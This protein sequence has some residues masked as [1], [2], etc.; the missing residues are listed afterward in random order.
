MPTGETMKDAPLDALHI[1]SIL[2]GSSRSMKR[3]QG[4]I[5]DLG[6]RVMQTRPGVRSPIGLSVVLHIPGNVLAPEFVGVRTESSHR[7]ETGLTVQ[8]ALEM[9]AS[10]DVDLRVW[11]GLRD[12]VKEAEVWAQMKRKADNLDGIKHL[13]EAV[14]P[15]RWHLPRKVGA[16]SPDSIHQ[17]V[18]RHRDVVDGTIRVVVG[19]A[20]GPPGGRLRQVA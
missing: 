11:E 9:E 5:R 3:W 7:K 2:G 8:I 10:V 20:H 18:R 15:T 17:P 19:E 14:R 16:Q 6:R 12:A 13:V 4:S 1:N